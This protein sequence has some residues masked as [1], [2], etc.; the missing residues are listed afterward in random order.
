MK[1]KKKNEIQAAFSFRV[2]STTPCC[3]NSVIRHRAYLPMFDYAV[4][5]MRNL[6]FW[7]SR[8]VNFHLS[9]LLSEK[10][11]LPTIDNYYIRAMMV[12]IAKGALNTKDPDIQ[13]SLDIWNGSIVANHPDDTLL[14]SIVGLNTITTSTTDEYFV[15]FK[16]YH[17]YALQKHWAYL[18]HQKYQVSKKYSNCIVISI[19]LMFNQEVI[20]SE[21]S[22]DEIYENAP[23]KLR[24][25]LEDIKSRELNRLKLSTRIQC[26]NGRLQI[27]RSIILEIERLNTGK[28]ISIAPVA[29]ARLPFVEFCHKSIENL[30]CFVI[31]KQSK[32]T[33]LP[34]LRNSLLMDYFRIPKNSPLKIPDKGEEV[35]TLID[36]IPLYDIFR[37]PKRSNW[38]YS[39]T[40]KTDGYRLHIIWQKQIQKNYTTTPEAID[41]RDQT[42]ARNEFAWEDELSKIYEYNCKEILKD[43]PKLKTPDKRKR[44]F[45]DKQLAVYSSD[46][47]IYPS[48]SVEDFNNQAPGIYSQTILDQVTIGS[49][50]YAVDPGM[51]DIMSCV[52]TTNFQTGE[53]TKAKRFSSKE[54]YHKIGIPKAENPRLLG[55]LS[56]ISFK[57]ISPIAILKSLLGFLKICV[58]YFHVFGNKNLRISSF[59]RYRR[60]RRLYESFADSM[61]PEKDAIIIM[62]NGK[63]QT[64]LRGTSTCPLAKLTQEVAKRRRVIYVKEN[65]T[66]QKCSCCHTVMN[67]LTDNKKGL[68]KTRSGRIYYPKIHGLRQ[69]PHCARTWNRDYNAARNICFAAQCFN[70]IG[71]YPSYLSKS[72]C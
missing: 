36:T 33:F 23:L 35:K 34:G 65:Y 24:Q 22:L 27:H 10:K 5:Q 39:P 44:L 16:N 42:I 59:K 7:G 14:P 29:T 15:A 52:K 20:T 46:S 43:K 1:K 57:S 63:I 71:E 38:E 50:T 60:K 47:L 17:L 45:L 70:S 31:S 53:L 58:D 62:G 55:I 2:L 66:T 54:F 18:I 12:S 9:R 26:L 56:Q 49:P 61:F 68:C 28:A 4:T 41:K 64:T 32:N 48:K 11:E 69:C 30:I 8:F 40:F 25:I 51:I 37:I 72:P 67:E 3:L 21:T 6:R 19:F 13:D